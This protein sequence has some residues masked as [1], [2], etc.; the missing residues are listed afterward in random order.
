MANSTATLDTFPSSSTVSFPWYH[1]PRP[2]LLQF[3]SDKN[4][5]VAV[6]VIVYWV[7]SLAFHFL[8]QTG[9]FSRYRIQESEEVTKRNRVTVYEVVRA[10]ALQ[11]LVQTLLGLLVLSEDPSEVFR[12]HGAEIART[13]LWVQRAAYLLL[14]AKWE[15]RLMQ[16]Y[17]V[18]LASW[19]YW[20]G[21]PIFQLFAAT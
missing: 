19:V 15:S 20:W 11:H 7:Y 16:R 5:S 6:P 3:I 2:S 9:L 8:D 18:Q 13:G 4:L 21:V 17:G 14:G 1:V 10:V 12:D